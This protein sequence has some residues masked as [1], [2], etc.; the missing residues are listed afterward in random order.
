[1]PRST[2]VTTRCMPLIRYIQS[3]G[4]I[5]VVACNTTQRT[6]IE[7]TF[8]H[9]DIIHLDGYN[10]LYSKWNRLGQIGLLSQLPRIHK[11][12]NAEH[13]WLLQLANERPI[14]GIISDNRYGLFHPNIPSVILTHQLQVQTGLGNFPDHA[15]QKLHYKYLDRFN[16]TW[17]VDA[18]GNPNL[19]GKLSHPAALPNHATYL[20]LLSRFETPT[21]IPP[22]PLIDGNIAEEPLLIL[23][24]GPEPQRNE[25]SRIL[26]QQVQHY[27]GKVTFVEGSENVIPPATISPHITYHK[28][29][30]SEQLAPILR[31]A[32]MVISRSGYSTLMD[33]VALRKKAIIIPTPGQTEQEYLGRHLHRQG[34]FYCT[35]QKR[36]DILTALKEAS[37]FPY[38]FLPLDRAYT[39]YKKVIDQWLHAL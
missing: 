27:P 13:N 36:F 17:V 29:L 11:T 37:Q 6:F 25:L 28:R 8:G 33:L 16:A 9:I 7:E 19:G 34:I 14:D 3:L 18:P 12:I 24:S 26:W 22:V 23:L 39:T 10:I 1:M 2:G 35:T 30:T 32:G 15:I 4:H 20:G 5:P 31:N 38:H 21:A